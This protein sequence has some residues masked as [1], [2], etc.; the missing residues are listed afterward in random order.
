MRSA[1]LA[2][3]SV[4]SLVASF[5][6]EAQTIGRM[7]RIGVLA[8][9]P[10]SAIEGL[11]DGLRD[12]GYVEGRDVTF[13]YAWAGTHSERFISLAADL[14]ERKPDFIVTWGTPAALAARTATSTIPIIMG[15]ISDPVSAGLVTNLARPGAN[16][17]GFSSLAADL[18][19]K[20]LELL[21]ELAPQLSRVAVLWRADN[22]VQAVASRTLIA[23]AKKLGVRVIAAKIIP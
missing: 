3:V 8:N 23:A 20:R 6:A 11:R 15:A 5:T 1:I 19:A 17:T 22:P 18:E 7:Y 14:T 13:D 9:E 16:I 12:L 2:V 10:S 4:L 21:K